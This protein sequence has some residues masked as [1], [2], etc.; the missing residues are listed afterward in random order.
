MRIVI[1][2]TPGVG[3]HIIAKALAE[4]LRMSTID[5]NKVALSN[6]VIGK[7]ESSYI[8]DTDKLRSILKGLKDN[9]IVIGHLAPYVLDSDDVD[10]VVV[11]RRS[12][13]ELREVYRE[14]RYDD[15]KA[16]DNLASEI[17][18]IITH[19]SVKQFKGKVI[20]IDC[21]GKDVNT[22]V[23]EILKI[24]NKKQEGMVGHIDWLG[25]VV[26]NNDLRGFFDY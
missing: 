3:K 11:L 23:D 21:T 2:G 24:V 20:E 25:L 8:V 17:L 19:D 10:L 1:T 4:M 5:I 18:G 14:R 16:K 15:S 12:P 7:D 13:Y 6:A 9:T 22:V 26:K